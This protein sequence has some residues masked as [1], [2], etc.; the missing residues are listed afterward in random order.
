MPSIAFA[1]VAKARMVR[2]LAS[3]RWRCILE[4][5]SMVA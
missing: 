5:L 3:G 2:L 4:I 1:E